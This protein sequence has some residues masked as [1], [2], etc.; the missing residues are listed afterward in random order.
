MSKLILIPVFV[1]LWS[2]SPLSYGFEL[3]RAVIP[4]Q[5]IQVII[6]TYGDSKP[7][8]KSASSEQKGHKHLATQSQKSLVT[9]KPSINQARTKLAINRMTDLEI[10][11]RS[12]SEKG[13]LS[14]PYRLTFFD[15]R[16]PDH[17]HGMVVQPKI[18]QLDDLHWKVEGFKLHMKGLWQFYI[19]MKVGETEEKA[20]FDLDI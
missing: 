18:S 8:S 19:T 12:L 10:S 7:N 11:V 5:G 13:K 15:A 9:E 3:G 6:E 16:M 17:N 14:G 1:F 2:L 4:S 20:S